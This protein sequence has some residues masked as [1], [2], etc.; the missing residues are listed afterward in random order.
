VT[1]A[2]ADWK[3]EVDAIEQR[4][5]SVLQPTYAVQAIKEAAIK[6]GPKPHG[7][8]K[9]GAEWGQVIHALLEAAMKQPAADLRGLAVAALECEE[10]PITLVEDVVAAVECVIASDLWQRAGSARRCLTEVPLAM[11]VPAAETDSSLPTVL[12]GVIDLVFLESAGW[13]IVDYKSERVEASDIP[14]LVTYYKPQIE[15]YAKVWEEVVG[16]P[17]GEAGLFF[18]HTGR[19]V[20][21]DRP[22]K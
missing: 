14:A 12:R 18:T 8:E 22:T 4:W 20:A 7:A 3:K 5:Q 11:L 2:P 16:Q 15:A 13:V 21:V 19:Y 1:I 17:V 6:G 10:L 9:S